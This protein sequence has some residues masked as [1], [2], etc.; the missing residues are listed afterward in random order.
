MADYTLYYWPVPFRGQ[1]IRAILAHAGK[2]WDEGGGNEADDLEAIMALPPAEQ[3]IPFMG[4]PVLIDAGNGFKLAEMPAIAFYLGETLHLLPPTPEGRALTLKVVNDANDVIDEITRDGGRDMW[5]PEKWQVFGP[6]LRRW[7]DI[8]E[9]TGSR[10]EL[11]PQEGFLLGGDEAGIADIVTAT[12]WGTLSDRFPVIGGILRAQAPLVAGLTG[13]LM[14]TRPLRD[15]LTWSN[16][17]FGD[18]YCGG[19]IEASLRKVVDAKAE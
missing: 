11:T 3:P 9:V 18:A 13:R 14:A 17:R 15:L 2:T 10:H 19:Q 6:R 12:L 5:T 4:P 1:F 16:N 8:F 7:M